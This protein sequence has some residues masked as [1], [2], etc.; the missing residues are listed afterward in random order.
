M[1]QVNVWSDGPGVLD[2]PM[3]MNARLSGQ[4]PIEVNQFVYVF[5]DIGLSPRHRYETISGRETNYT[6]VYQSNETISGTY[7]MIVQVFVYIWGFKGWL[8]AEDRHKFV[9]QDT[10]AGNINITQSGVSQ[11]ALTDGIVATNR[12]VQLMAQI[13]YGSHVLKNSSVCNYT[14]VL[15]SKTHDANP[16]PVFKYNFTTNATFEVEVIIFCNISYM[17]TNI[18]KFG[19]FTT[20]IKAKNEI[21]GLNVTGNTWL[22]DGALLQL[23]VHCR[24]G[25]KPFWYCY[26]FSKKLRPNYT[27]SKELIH[28]NDC[29]FPITHYFPYNGTYYI[30]IGI[31]NDVN[32]V[33]KTIK[34]NVYDIVRQ[35]QLSFVIIPVV[36]SILAIVIV[37][38]GIAYH[39]QQRAN[40]NITL[41][42]ADFDFQQNDDLVEKTFFE[43]L[44]TSIATAMRETIFYPFNPCTRGEHYNNLIDDNIATNVAINTND[45]SYGITK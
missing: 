19:H 24:A 7:T 12:E 25:D 8:I 11:K 2:I 20:T 5:E 9:L 38:A 6:V 16:S 29:Y 44:R 34:V 27:C 43:R 17:K 21:Q 35:T 18:S 22:L 10:L 14:W 41:E 3:T 28:T 37:V 4:M 39:L 33:N 32:F 30:D 40:N 26:E 31:Y 1:A 23:K 36:S 42:V 13:N 15:E 45:V